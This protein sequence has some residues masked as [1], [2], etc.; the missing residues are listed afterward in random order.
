[1]QQLNT[2]ARVRWLRTQLGRF[3]TLTSDADPIHLL[4]LT[5]YHAHGAWW[6][7]G[8]DNGDIGEPLMVNL[9]EVMQMPGER[10]LRCPTMRHRRV[11]AHYSLPVA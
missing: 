5:V 10:P 6:L 8:Y 11:R 1:M 3:V 9:A 2:T 4:L 7:L